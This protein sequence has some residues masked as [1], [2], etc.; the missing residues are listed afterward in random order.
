MLFCYLFGNFRCVPSN[1]FY[2][3]VS[4]TCSGWGCGLSL[5][6][7]FSFHYF[8]VLFYVSV[9]HTCSEWNWALRL[10]FAFSSCFFL[11]LFHVSLPLSKMLICLIYLN[12]IC[13]FVWIVVFSS[14]LV[15]PV[16]HMHLSQGPTVWLTV[17]QPLVAQC[18]VGTSNRS[19]FYRAS[20]QVLY[21]M[22]T[23]PGLVLLLLLQAFFSRPQFPPVYHV[24]PI[25]DP[26][27]LLGISQAQHAPLN[28][29]QAWF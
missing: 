17:P 18:K 11:V 1:T 2:I 22:W 20:W 19:S 13:L 23:N 15:S 26:T 10:H 4:F 12:V 25:W 3:N 29:Q 7:V 27:V 6:F 24:C 16:H 14:S 9:C 21:L 5:H 28:G 8:L